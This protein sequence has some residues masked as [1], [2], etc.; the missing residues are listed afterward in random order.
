MVFQLRPPALDEEGLGSVL[1]LYLEEFSLDSGIAYTLRDELESEPPPSQTSVL[2]RI[3]QE[4]LTNVRKHSQAS[5]VTV[6]LT[7]VDGGVRLRV[8]DDGVGLPMHT[9][10]IG[11]LRHIGVPEMRE[12]AQIAGGRLT[13]LSAPGG[14]TIVEA[15]IPRSDADVESATPRTRVV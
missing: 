1:R 11:A 6:S 12:R 10:A 9:D 2:Y 5:R 4:A 7:E 13:I 14:G 15:W 8:E 3:A